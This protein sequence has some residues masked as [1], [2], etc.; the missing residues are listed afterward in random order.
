[1]LLILLVSL[2]IINIECGSIYA[3]TGKSIEPSVNNQNEV[4][5]YT[6]RFGISTET[7]SSDLI[8][9]HFPVQYS[10]I[11]ADNTKFNCYIL[12]ELP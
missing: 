11:P 2:V 6:F 5:K 4:S 1:M 3:L 9:I 12:P 7:L 10:S 8:V